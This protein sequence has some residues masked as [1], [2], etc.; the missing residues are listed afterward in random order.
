MKTE[1]GKVILDVRKLFPQAVRRAEILERLKRSWPSVVG[2]P[3]A[4]YSWPCVLGV[5]VLTVEAVNEQARNRL[6]NMRGNILRG[7]TRLG[8]EAGE[9]FTVRINERESKKKL[10]A[11][12]PACVKV[13]ES[14]ERLRQ[15]MS[16]AP[17]T[18]PEDINFALSHLKMHLDGRKTG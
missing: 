18:L 10:L 8:Y 7:L 1:D 2:M 11:K 12:K 17:D 6:A 3:V 13:I 9:N 14:E 4:R 5:D 15:Y 16:G